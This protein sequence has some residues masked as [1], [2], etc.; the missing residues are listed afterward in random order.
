VLP[1]WVFEFWQA[2]LHREDTWPEN[3]A[4]LLG[5]FAFAPVREVSL[6]RRGIFNHHV[7]HSILESCR[8]TQNAFHARRV[9]SDDADGRECYARC[10]HIL[11]HAVEPLVSYLPGTCAHVR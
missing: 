10:C 11:K 6:M 3:R 4:E 1:R 5:L 2:E 8:P 7:V 9:G